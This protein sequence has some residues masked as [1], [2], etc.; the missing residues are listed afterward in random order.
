[1]PRPLQISTN[2]EKLQAVEIFRFVSIYMGKRARKCYQHFKFLALLA[3]MQ[4]RK[5]I[6][7]P[8]ILLNKII[9][10]IFAIFA[11]NL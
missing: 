10:S 7:S 6:G 3:L 11:K 5:S 8:I 9:S 2:S 1:M 4:A